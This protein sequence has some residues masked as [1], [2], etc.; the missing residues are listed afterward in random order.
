MIRKAKH[1]RLN[2]N[3]GE[4]EMYLSFLLQ[5]D[6]YSNMF[7][8]LVLQKLHLQ[9]IIDISQGRRD[10]IIEMRIPNVLSPSLLSCEMALMAL[11]TS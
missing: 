5:R 2:T 9:G 4:P 7:I 11:P 10:S 6:Q 1:S 3:Q 8:H